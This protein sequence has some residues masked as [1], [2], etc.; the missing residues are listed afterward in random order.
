MRHAIIEEKYEL[1]TQLNHKLAKNRGGSHVPGGSE[2][3]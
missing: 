2:C 3:G 1:K